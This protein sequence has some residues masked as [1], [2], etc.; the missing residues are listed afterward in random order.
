MANPGKVNFCSCYNKPVNRY[1]RRMAAFLISYKN[2]PAFIFKF[3]A[4]GWFGH[5]GVLRE[6]RKW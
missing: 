2:P 4:S 1:A 5:G 3:I 6:E